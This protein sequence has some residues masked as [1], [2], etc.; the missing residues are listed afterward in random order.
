[1][2]PAKNSYTLSILN[3]S[4]LP[5]RISPVDMRKI[6][7]S[8]Q[9]KIVGNGISQNSNTILHNGCYMDIHFSF[10][11]SDLNFK[12]LTFEIL[13]DERVLSLQL[14][15]TLLDQCNVKNGI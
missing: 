7:H 2:K 3:V 6:P 12:F 8:N 1:M 15:I 13:I 10:Q 14:P 11:T 9:I 5:L 4:R